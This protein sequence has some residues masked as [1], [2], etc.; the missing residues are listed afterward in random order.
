MEQKFYEKTVNWRA[1]LVFLRY[2]G[3]PVC[4]LA[5]ADIKRNISLIEKAGASLFVVLQSSSS[6]LSSVTKR[7]DWPFTILSDP[8]GN[9]FKQCSVEA[10]GI[11]KYLPPAGFIAVIKATI[12][13]VYAWKI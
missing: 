1:V 4:R 13:G 12:I 9:I 2:I 5:M 3:C 7:E 11:L 6:N 10:G 8:K